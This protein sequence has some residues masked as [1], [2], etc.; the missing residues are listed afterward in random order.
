MGAA[1][2]TADPVDGVRSALG[3]GE[4]ASGEELGA[5]AERL[6]RV[7]HLGGRF[8]MVEFSPEVAGMLKA[9]GRGKLVC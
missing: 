2:M 1:V 8:A 4:Q 7:R 9:V 6:E 5:L 3:A